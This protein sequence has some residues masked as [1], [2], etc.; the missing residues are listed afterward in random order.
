MTNEEVE[1]TTHLT[2]LGDSSSLNG[3]FA[4]LYNELYCLALRELRRHAGLI[5]SPAALLHDIY[6]DMSTNM[7]E[8]QAC[9]LRSRADFL[10]YAACVMRSL[11]REH[12]GCGCGPV[13]RPGIAAPSTQ[14]GRDLGGAERIGSG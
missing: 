7:S 4:D 2:E 10:A 1:Q 13:D 8:R 6:I 3:L 12:R 5:M 14:F 9:A 11:L